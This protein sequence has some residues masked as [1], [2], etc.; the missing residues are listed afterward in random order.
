MKSF[1]NDLLIAF[2]IL[3]FNQKKEPIWTGKLLELF[4]MSTLQ[5]SASLDTLTDWDIIYGEYGT[6]EQGRAGYCYFINPDHIG[7][8]E[9]IKK[10][11]EC[12]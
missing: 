2:K 8:L 3:E 9:K 5:V 7:T 12:K 1:S 11:G 4:P 10:K 6:T